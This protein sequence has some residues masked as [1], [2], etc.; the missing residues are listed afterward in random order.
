MIGPVHC[1][2]SAL[3]PIITLFQNKLVSIV[4]VYHR[5]CIISSTYTWANAISIVA[6]YIKNIP[7]S[8]LDVTVCDQLNSFIWKKYPFRWAQATLTSNTGELLL[9]NGRQDYA[10]GTL[11]GGGFYQ[12]LRVRIARTDVTPNVIREKS[13][14]NWLAPNLETTG[15]ID[16]IQAM[17]YEPVQNKIRLDRAASVSGTT[18]Y[19]IQG[20]Y[21]FQPVKVT[22]TAA[23]IVFPDQYF[24]VVMEGLKWKF[25]QLGDDKRAG[26]QR[27][28][29][30]AMLEQMVEDEDYGNATGQRFP[31]DV[32]GWSHASNPG[33]FGNY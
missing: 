28:V 30:L 15:A 21:W 33:I 2:Q 22:S 5:R 14:Q 7:T 4:Q 24:D 9:V 3:F 1:Q 32:M 13:I 6:P 8:T 27:A 18:T 17:C 20:E 10:I 23:P 25:Y 12:L 16:S 29:F 26:E 19:L 31:G 11:T